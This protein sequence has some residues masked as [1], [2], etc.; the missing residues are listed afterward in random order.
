MQLNRADFL[1]MRTALSLSCQK[2]SQIFNTI[3]YLYISASMVHYNQ[4][5][6]GFFDPTSKSENIEVVT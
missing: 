4:D 3:L 6:M 5:E 1:D 2:H